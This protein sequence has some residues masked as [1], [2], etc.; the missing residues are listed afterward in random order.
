MNLIYG[1]TEWAVCLKSCTKSD[2]NCKWQPLEG[3]SF[4]LAMAT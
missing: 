1:I 3:A 4:N 2:W